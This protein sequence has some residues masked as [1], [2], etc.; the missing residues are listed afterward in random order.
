[1]DLVNY[2]V[3]STAGNGFEARA[4]SMAMLA[5]PLS[6]L[7]AGRPVIDK[8]ELKGL[9]DI[10]LEWNRDAGL[11]APTGDGAISSPAGPS[12]ITAVADQLGLKLES[13][14]GPLAVLVI[15]SVQRPTEN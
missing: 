11:I 3:I 5:T 15:D 12:L 10:K 8:T 4:Q 9:Y 6:T 2:V 13:A 14:K 7:Y 1:M